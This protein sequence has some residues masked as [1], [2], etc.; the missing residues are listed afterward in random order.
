MK[1]EFK[2][3][4]SSTFK[5]EELARAQKSMT[6]AATKSANAFRKKGRNRAAVRETKKGLNAVTQS[7]KTGTKNELKRVSAYGTQGVKVITA[8]TA[9]NVV[10]HNFGG[11]GLIPGLGGGGNNNSNNNNNNNSGGGSSNT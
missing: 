3:P 9:S 11:G 8:L 7:S 1:E 6:E 5:D 10:S 4:I 2:R